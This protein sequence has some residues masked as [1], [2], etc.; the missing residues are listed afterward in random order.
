MQHLAYDFLPQLH[1]SSS[2]LTTSEFILGTP[3][4]T[5]TVQPHDLVHC[6][7]PAPPYS[8]TYQQ[9]RSLKWTTTGTWNSHFLY[10]TPITTTASLPL[11]PNLF[12]LS[13]HQVQTQESSSQPITALSNTNTPI[14]FLWPIFSEQTHILH[15][16]QCFCSCQD[17]CWRKPVTALAHCN[18]LMLT[19]TAPECQQQSP[20]SLLGTFSPTGLHK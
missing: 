18:M 1:S 20:D 2:L 5:L 15:T 10:M 6:N 11:T 9:A 16:V 13:A 7:P 19:F 17:H 12:L 4:V 3:G 8:A 14:K